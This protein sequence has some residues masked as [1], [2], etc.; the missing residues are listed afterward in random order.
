LAVSSCKVTVLHHIPFDDDLRPACVGERDRLA[1]EDGDLLV[2]AFFL[3]DVERLGNIGVLE[4]FDLENRS[5]AGEPSAGTVITVGG[6]LA[7][8]KTFL[9]EF[10]AYAQPSTLVATLLVLLMLTAADTAMAT[11]AKAMAVCA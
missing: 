10:K 5:S 2:S 3:P 4:I 11:A 9:Q 1:K 7:M 6:L 8:K